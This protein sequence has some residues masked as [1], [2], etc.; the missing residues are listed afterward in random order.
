MSDGEFGTA[1]PTAA[2]GRGNADGAVAWSERSGKDVLAGFE[3]MNGEALA[4]IRLELR[5]PLA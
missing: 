3:S 2:D 4:T 1:T 5:G